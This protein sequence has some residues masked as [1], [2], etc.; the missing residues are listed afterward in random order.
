[1]T[2]T[3]NTFV[4]IAL[5][6]LVACGQSK[7]QQAAEEKHKMDSTAQA[8][9]TE[10][11]HQ[12]AL[13]DSIKQAKIQQEQNKETLTNNLVDLK[14]RLAAAQSKM[15]DIQSFQ[16]GRSHDEKDQQIANQTKVIEELKIQIAD[17]ETQLAK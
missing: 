5:L 16:F 17:L 9:K 7:E 13:Q 10:L 8:T 14:G 12:Q 11:L 3:K 4:G 15:S 1:M 2:K 6:T